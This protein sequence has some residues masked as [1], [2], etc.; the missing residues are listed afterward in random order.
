MNMLQRFCLSLLLLIVFAVNA[1]AT[2]SIIVIDPKTREIGIA[3]ASCTYN[4]YGIGAVIPGKGAIV[5]QAMS[6]YFARVKGYEMILA[7]APPDS[8]IK[9]MQD[10]FFDPEEQ[11]YAIVSI[12]YL[13]KPA[14]YTGKENEPHKGALTARG[15]SVQG[16]TLAS[17]GE[18][19]A[20]LDAALKA[21]K[22]SLRIEEVLMRALE[23]GAA[24]GGDKRC[25]NTKASSAFITVAQPG[26]DMRKPSLNLLVVGNDETV[27]AVEAL[28]KKLDKW[29]GRPGK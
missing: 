27:N 26:D 6:N 2:W 28:R 9:A 12:R 17:A 11:Q 3:G 16:N 5:V 13:D 21:Q 19:Q 25:G 1:N 20:V 7:D 18:L 23:A 15:I 24:H 22:E 8:I 29:K 4:V 10:P 14:T